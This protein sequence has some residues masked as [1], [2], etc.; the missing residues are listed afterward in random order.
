MTDPNTSEAVPKRTLV[1]EGTEFKGSV[2][3]TCPILVK[4]RMTG[5]VVAPSLEISATGAVNGRVKVGQ[6][7]SQGELSGEI[8]AD[9]VQL[10]GTVKD[11]T[12]VRAKSLEVKLEADGASR[13][14][15]VFGECVLDVGDAPDRQAA[16]ASTREVPAP[17]EVP[18]A[19]A[20]PEAVPMVAP[21][22]G[23]AQPSA[24][25]R[26][27]ILSHDLA[28]ARAEVVR[29][30]DSEADAAEGAPQPLPNPLK[31][32]ADPAEGDLPPVAKPA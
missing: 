8:D 29:A 17:N 14:Q 12:V 10:S 5:D 3:S 11:R 24:V 25:S 15:V 30:P 1:E 2:S 4:G 28:S 19:D 6:I 18:R 16:I 31:S 20:P 7:R 9:V 22:S 13:M 23:A 27:T 26:A 32:E 21:K